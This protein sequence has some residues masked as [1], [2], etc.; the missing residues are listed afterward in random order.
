M[1]NILLLLGRESFCCSSRHLSETQVV[2]LNSNSNNVLNIF[3][4][5]KIDVDLILSIHPDPKYK[6]VNFSN[7]LNK[8]QDKSTAPEV[9]LF[10]FVMINKLTN[11][12]N[13]LNNRMSPLKSTYSTVTKWKKFHSTSSQRN[14]PYLKSMFFFTL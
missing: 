2:M 8:N 7:C 5:S 11:M 9:C 6:Q 4:T 13:L 12:V 3:K 10:S 14:N 1:P